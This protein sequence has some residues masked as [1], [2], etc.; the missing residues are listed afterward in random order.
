M[1]NSAPTTQTFLSLCHTAV[2]LKA[3]LED[4][5]TPYLYF[6]NSQNFS[7]YHCILKTFVVLKKEFCAHPFCCT[8]IHE[9][10]PH[11]LII[12]FWAIRLKV[13]KRLCHLMK[14]QRLSMSL[15]TDLHTIIFNT[16]HFATYIPNGKIS[17][18]I[19][20]AN[21]SHLHATAREAESSAA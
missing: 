3:P 6:L 21:S 4:L 7:L 5:W 1:C 13:T 2:T 20:K 8:T 9:Q 16:L 18:I 11:H 17:F 15:L 12:F 10:K 19:W 14:G